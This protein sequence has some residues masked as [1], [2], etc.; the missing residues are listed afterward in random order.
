VKLDM[1]Q[2]LAAL[3]DIFHAGAMLA[4]GLGMPL[5]FWH[6]FPRLSRAYMWFSMAFVVITVASQAVLGE[7]F[8]TTLA[9]ELWLA[10]DGFR[11]RVPFTVLVTEWVAGIRPTAREAVLL[12]ELGV[13]ASSAG[14]L[15]CW[16]RTA[17]PRPARYGRTAR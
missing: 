9:R 2:L 14:G 4:W 15:W 3:T 12:W 10:G 17:E 16:Y 7:C 11:E 8:L 5:L 1:L 6:R 13:F